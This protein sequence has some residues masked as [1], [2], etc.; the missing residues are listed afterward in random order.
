MN[1]GVMKFILYNFS[2]AD[3]DGSVR[4][5]IGEQLTVK[6]NPRIHIKGHYKDA[7]IQALKVNIIKN[8][9]VIKAFEVNSPYEL[10][11]EDSTISAGKNYY[12]IDLASADL[13]LITNPIFVIS[14]AS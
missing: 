12:R 11:F 3:A 10:T 9:K 8:G 14:L 13:Q 4:A 2:V 6:G 1:S 7:K 5:I